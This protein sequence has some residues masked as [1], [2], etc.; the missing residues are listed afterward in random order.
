MQLILT[1][2]QLH[3]LSYF[4]CRKNE[5]NKL[6]GLSSQEEK[7]IDSWLGKANSRHSFQN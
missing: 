1:L 4:S 3:F 2:L 5:E 6:H 7:K